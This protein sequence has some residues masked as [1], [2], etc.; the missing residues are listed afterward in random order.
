MNIPRWISGSFC[1]EKEISTPTPLLPC[2]LS[3][4][5]HPPNE[6]KFQCNRLP[7]GEKLRTTNLFLLV[8][9]LSLRLMFLGYPA[10]DYSGPAVLATPT[11]VMSSS[12]WRESFISLSVSPHVPIGQSIEWLFGSA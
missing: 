10:T 8:P 4:W 6:E 11:A 1:V 9:L 7:R 3:L 2:C 12:D 5:G